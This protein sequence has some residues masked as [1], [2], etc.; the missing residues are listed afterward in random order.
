MKH[1]FIGLLAIILGLWGIVLNWYQFLDLL[2]VLIPM[3][4]L[5]G[6][7]VALMAG[8]SNFSKTPSKKE[9]DIEERLEGN[10]DV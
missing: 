8:I 10:L 4:V 2:W 1:I 9:N 7:I 6:G 3:A 5:C